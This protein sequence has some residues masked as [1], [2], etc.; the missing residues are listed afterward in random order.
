[1]ITKT[2]TGAPE[3]TYRSWNFR[4]KRPRAGGWPLL[5]RTGHPQQDRKPSR[6]TPTE[7]IIQV[8]HDAD[9]QLKVSS[10]LARGT[11][12]GT[13]LRVNERVGLGARPGL[14]FVVYAPDWVEELAED[15]VARAAAEIG[16]SA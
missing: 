14:A 12:T 4:Y 13:T 10:V 11:W 7:L 2:R 16:A 1:M 3:I 6:I 5:T 9:G 15:A 8:R